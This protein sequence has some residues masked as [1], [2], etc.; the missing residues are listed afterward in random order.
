MWLLLGTEGEK[1][2]IER[3]N[4][5]REEWMEGEQFRRVVWRRRAVW[6]L[7]S[8]GSGRFSLLGESDPEEQRLC[9]HVERVTKGQEMQIFFF[10]GRKNTKATRWEV[11]VG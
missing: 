4:E 6:S 9:G 7:N 1:T 5:N 2:G 8:R 10:R 3:D 11:W